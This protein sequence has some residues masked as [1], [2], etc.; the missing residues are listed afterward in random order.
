MKDNKPNGFGV[1]IRN[2]T[3]RAGTFK[4]GRLYKGKVQVFNLLNNVFL[5]CFSGEM[6][7]GQCTGYGE[8]YQD[9]ILVYSGTYKKGLKSGLGKEYNKNGIV[10]DGGFKNGQRW[11]LGREFDDNGIIYDGEW[12]N[13]K[14]SGQGISFNSRGLVEY[15]GEWKNGLYNGKGKL[16]KNGECIEAR[17]KNGSK[18]ETI[19]TSIIKQVKRTSSLFLEGNNRNSDAIEEEDTVSIQQTKKQQ[20]F[21]ESLSFQLH[22][23]VTNEI[24]TRVNKRFNLFQIP[25]MVFQPYF[26]SEATRA[27]KPMNSYPKIFLLRIWKNGLIM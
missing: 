19:A 26:S 27:K 9:G 23:H 11:G 2:D 15:E 12:A 3:L 25:R 4:E 20:D 21:I 8:S 24:E 22:E 13:G 14:Y 7:K 6:E 10:Y 16:Y 17:W 1:L 18:H 5:P